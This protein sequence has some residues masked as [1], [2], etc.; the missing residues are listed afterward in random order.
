MRS[1]LECLGAIFIEVYYV[2]R[3]G[4]VGG[5]GLVRRA[6]KYTHTHLEGLRREFHIS[7]RVAHTHSEHMLLHTHTH[8]CDS[9]IYAV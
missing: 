4:V 8:W 6:Q 1:A 3:G 7:L 5:S 9:G 2:R